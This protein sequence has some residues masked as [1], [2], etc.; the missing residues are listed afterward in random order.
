M[1][2]FSS[3]KFQQALKQSHTVAHRMTGTNAGYS[4]N[5]NWTRGRVTQSYDDA[6]RWSLDVELLIPDSFSVDGM[7][8]FLNTRSTVLRPG[9][10]ILFPDGTSEYIDFANFYI[11]NVKV[12]EATN[13]APVMQVE[14]YDRSIRAQGNLGRA[15]SI[16]LGTSPSVAVP[17]IIGLKVPGA[18]Y[19]LAATPFQTPVLLLTPD[20][21]G[22]GEAT[23]L[24]TSVGQNLYVDRTDR[25]V[26]GVRALGPSTDYV[27]H[28]NENS[29]PDFWGIL[30]SD[31]NDL[32]PNVIRVVGT[33][34]AFPGVVGEASDLNP[35]SQTYR[36]SDYGEQV[37]TFQSEQVTT[38]AQ[39][40]AMAQYLL[41]KLLGPQDE[42]EFEA[43][44]NP[45]LDVGDTVWV[46]RASM[47]LSAT[48][49]L[50][51]KIE[52]PMQV[53]DAMHVTCRRSLFSEVTS[54]PARS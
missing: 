2:A 1:V 15:V 40:N 37:A 11:A 25:F 26:S 44:P 9:R 45:A 7:R 32:H 18:T 42:I 41:S 20:M 6:S 31:T 23:R 3:Q 22:W 19:A 50:V 17:Q 34:P 30:R 12:A 53:D 54:L 52:M 16:P 21:D 38:E 28:F 27:W 33:N 5:L 10:G 36:Y 47:G 14:A 8:T 13:G 49:L 39:A 35:L 43:I 24:M 4:V 46:T 51:V 48:P 29:Y